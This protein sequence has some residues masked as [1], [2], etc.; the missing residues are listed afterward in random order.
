M[1]ELVRFSVAMPDDLMD[2]L[3]DYTKRR[4]ISKNRSEVIRN[5]V[6]AA[7]VD[8]HVED[9]E[10]DIVGTLTM[11]FNHHANDLRD[12]L[13]SIQHEHVKEIVSTIHVH[14]DEENCLEVV[15]MRGKSR[16][17]RCIS[18]TLLGTKG[19]AHGDLFVTSV[20]VSCCEHGHSH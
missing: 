10:S 13:D 20:N 4:G 11:V 2:E 15:V 7:L 9:P 1:S 17:V 14:L 3:D 18:D 19:V 12:K 6:R 8:D 16:V 5:L